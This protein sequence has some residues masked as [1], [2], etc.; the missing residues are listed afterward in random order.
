MASARSSN[1]HLRV[2]PREMKRWRAAAKRADET[3]SE[4]L[5]NLANGASIPPLPHVPRT[6]SGDQVELP[7]TSDKKKKVAS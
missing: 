3:L 6:V 7:F 4:W 5:R 1:V 2:K